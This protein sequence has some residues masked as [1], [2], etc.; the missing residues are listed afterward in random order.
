MSLSNRLLRDDAVEA[1]RLVAGPVGSVDLPERERLFRH[2]ARDL[3]TVELLALVLGP[4]GRATAPVVARQLLARYPEP[5]VLAG[6]PVE[7]LQD[8]P[9]VGPARAARL[10]AACELG[11]RLVGAAPRRGL[12]VGGPDDLAVLLRRE[13]SGRDREHVVGLYLDARHRL[14]AM[15]T[16]SVGTLNAS[17]V[18]PREV[19]RPAVGMQAAAV[20][21]AHNHPSGCARPSGDDLELT[22]RLQRCGRLLGIELLDHLIVGDDE[23]VS[24]REHGWPRVADRPDREGT[25]RC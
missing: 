13:L 23:V 25:D 24:I 15:R 22:R 21:L 4:G 7:V 5:A 16:V 11:R 14:L 2:G 9:G 1:R 6:V 18:H 20:V 8:L 12:R 19:F 17:L 3:G 10:H